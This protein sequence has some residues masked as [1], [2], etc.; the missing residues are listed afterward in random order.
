MRCSSVIVK[1]NI[2]LVASILTNIEAFANN[3][4]FRA[5]IVSESATNSLLTF[6]PTKIS[7][8]LYNQKEDQ[9][10]HTAE[11]VA[12]MSRGEVQ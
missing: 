11:R 3:A 7:S 4:L 12:G 10:F 1:I 6:V 5:K 8:I 9:M 2:V